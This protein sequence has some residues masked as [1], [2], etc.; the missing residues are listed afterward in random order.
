MVN[1]NRSGSPE[2]AM[3]VCSTP[4]M[5]TVNSDRAVWTPAKVMLLMI[6]LPRKT[7]R[8][9]RSGA[10]PSPKAALAPDAV[11]APVPPAAIGRGV[12]KSVAISSMSAL[13]GTGLTM[14]PGMGVVPAG[15]VYKPLPD[16]GIDHLL[17]TILWVC[18]AMFSMDFLELLPVI[19]AVIV[20]NA[21][22]FFFFMAAMKCSQLQKSG[23]KDDELPAWVYAGL[24]VA[25]IF[26][27]TG[28]ALLA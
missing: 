3:L 12:F 8:S 13:Y 28:F 10:V 6:P 15:L 5:N 7:C 16:L 2:G 17:L 25:P 9:G 4:P 11:D 27:M 20:G 22:S 21:V 23:A 26:G 24:I 1:A 19:A 14:S 18:V